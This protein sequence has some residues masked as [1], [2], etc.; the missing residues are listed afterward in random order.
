MWGNWGSERW[1]DLHKVT[2]PEREALELRERPCD[3]CQSPG[4]LPRNQWFIFLSYF[5]LRLLKPFNL[6]CGGGRDHWAEGMRREASR[7]HPCPSPHVGADGASPKALAFT[8]QSWGT[9]EVFWVFSQNAEEKLPNSKEDMNPWLRGTRN[10]ILVSVAYFS[11]YSVT[12]S[13]NPLPHL[14]DTMTNQCGVVNEDGDTSGSHSLRKSDYWWVPV[15]W[16]QD[17]PGSKNC[18]FIKLVTSTNI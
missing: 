9:S 15:S 3:W 13:G 18:I 7:G 14:L 10:S 11:V 6:G 4:C 17:K 5:R 12:T 16:P 8:S 1:S 2:Q